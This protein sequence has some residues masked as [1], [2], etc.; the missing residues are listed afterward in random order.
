MTALQSYFLFIL[1]NPELE[2]MFFECHL[3]PAEI[4]YPANIVAKALSVENYYCHLELG[5]GQALLKRK[6]EYCFK[7]QSQ[8]TLTERI[9]CKFS[10]FLIAGIATA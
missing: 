3:G 10:I 1:V 5:D 9:Y 8:M 6:N 4:K 7:I 2:K